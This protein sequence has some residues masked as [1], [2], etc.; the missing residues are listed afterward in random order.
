MK[1]RLMS[2]LICT[3]LLVMLIPGVANAAGVNY[4]P[5]V[6]GI[7]A[8][9]VKSDKEFETLVRMVEKANK[10]IEKAVEKAQATPVDDV[11]ELLATVD[12]IVAKVF[13]YADSIGATVVCEYTEYYIDG[14]YVLIDP[15]RIIP[16]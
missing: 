6:K 14:Q 4:S 8:E 2:I 10:K 15:L 13:A 11:D 1:K 9:A 12:A 16:V 7:S 3:L 5:S